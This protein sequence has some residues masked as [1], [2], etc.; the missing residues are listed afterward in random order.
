ML[1]ILF[2]NLHGKK[3]GDYIVK[4]IVEND[5][6]IAIFA[7]YQDKDDKSI[8]LDSSFIESKLGN[9]FVQVTGVETDGKVLLLAKRTITVEQIQ[10][11]AR[12]SCYIIETAIK[13]YLLAAV[14]LEDRL[15]YPE[16][17]RRIKTI[18]SLTQDIKKNE[19]NLGIEN[20][21]VIG[22]FN[23][24]PYDKELLYKDAFNAVLFKSLIMENE[25]TNPK[26][27][28]IRRFY[29]P[30]IHYLSEDTKMYGSHYYDDSDK[31]ATPYW[32]CLDQVLV[33]KS[34]VD[35]LKE[36]RYLKA[37]DGEGL[38]K[39]SRPDRNISDHLPLLVNILEVED[40]V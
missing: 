13:R 33:R 35:L 22:D 4:C 14:H 7:E 39:G 26:G 3:N 1:N 18:C 6:D 15:N 29:N 27:D 32:H 31:R 20:T 8:V 10:Q 25:F 21:I 37:I 34:L 16:P 17:D 23:A 11:E 38:L 9:M 36:V 24:N 19:E 12:Y 40:G 5:V 28:R 30:I 2:W